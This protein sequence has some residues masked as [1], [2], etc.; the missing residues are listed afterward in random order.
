MYESI[1][2]SE[3]FMNLWIQKD[4]KSA[5]LKEQVA[6][7][8]PVLENLRAKKEERIKSFT[9]VKLQIEKISAEIR[10]YEHQQEAPLSAVIVD[11]YDLSTRK[12]DE[13]RTQLRTLQKD[14]VIHS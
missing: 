1:Q 10:E 13:Y 12:L 11:E 8:T 9:D 5:P 6:S 4:K 7:V 14:K 2:S 3:V